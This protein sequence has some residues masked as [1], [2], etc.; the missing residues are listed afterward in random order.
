MSKSVKNQDS[1]NQI[2]KGLFWVTCGKGAQAFLQFLVLIILSRLISPLDFGILSAAMIVVGLSE[3]ITELG[4]EAAIVQRENLEDRHVS[5]AFVSSLILSSAGG[6]L[7]YL[8]A[9]VLAGFFHSQ[10]VD[11]VLKALAWLFP[12]RGLATIGEALV[13]RELRFRWMAAVDTI[14]FGIGYFIFGAGLALLG[15]GVWALVTASLVTAVVKTSTLLFSYPPKSLRPEK[16]AFSE[17]LYFG[18]GHTVARISNNLALQGDNLVVARTLDLFSLGIY[19][20]AYQL[21]SVPASILGQILDRVLFPTFAKIQSQK[22]RLAAAYMRVITL[23]ALL[24]LPMSMAGIIV[25]PELID[26][27]LGDKWVDVVLPFR[28]LLIGLMMRT[29]YK[30]SDSLV[31]A[32]GAVYR[33]AWRQAIYAGMVI[34]GAWIG[35][36]WGIAGVAAGVLAAVA[37]NFLLMA[38][39]SLKLV[40]RNW[41]EFFA[42]H[43]NAFVSAIALSVIT[44]PLVNLLREINLMP[45]FILISTTFLITILFFL[46]LKIAPRFFFGSEGLWFIGILQSYLPK[47][48]R[49]SLFQNQEKESQIYGV[50]D[51]SIEN[52]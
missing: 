30:L 22:D 51:A 41:H 47:R 37:I 13:Q 29:S 48:I 12:I 11:E 43:S 50:K 44:L 52:A 18:C 46:G 45:I 35:H 38:G 14:S 2:A 8:L 42:A 49:L 21:M 28:I 7:I 25:A 4:L 40:G 31:R 27:I 34:S 36:F 20:R 17:L 6:L 32:T 24:M 3:I 19:G 5:T 39:L 23:V 33:R 26:V 15:F 1:S 9:P 16:Q 10:Q